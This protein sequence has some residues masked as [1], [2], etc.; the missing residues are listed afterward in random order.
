MRGKP[1]EQSVD[2][3]RRLSRP[4]RAGALAGAALLAVA[5]CGPTPGTAPDSVNPEPPA[6]A[7]ASAAAGQRSTAPV[8]GSAMAGHIHNLAYD[9]PRL[10]VGTHDGLWAQAPGSQPEQVS[11]ESFDV[12]GFARGDDR[13]L[14]SGHPGEGMDAPG[15]LGL[16]ESTDAGRTWTEVSLGGEVDFHRLA[17]SGAVVVG[18]SAHDG[19]LLRSE[20]AGSS[21]SDL[22]TPQLFDLAIDPADP[23]VIVATTPD[24]PARSTDG[25]GTFELLPGVPLIALLA[26]TSDALYGIDVDGTVHTSSDAGS[27]WTA[28]A[29]VPGQPAALAATGSTVAVHVGDAVLE[30]QDGG[31]TFT[32]RITDLQGH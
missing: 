29:T 11:A 13:S 2:L 12:M 4:L 17:T 6:V 15:D 31:A 20:D 32:P 1:S 14:A 24:G 18:I 28:G 5:A 7:S 8:D 25:G 23:A 10:L 26:W 21:W 19:R 9:G 3:L 22:G 16:L 27:T 30:S